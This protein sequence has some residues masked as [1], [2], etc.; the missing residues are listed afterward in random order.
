MGSTHPL[1]CAQFQ[2]N[3]PCIGIHAGPLGL[4]KRTFKGFRTL[5]ER[6]GR[7]DE[8]ANVQTH[9]SASFVCPRGC[10][11]SHS[12]FFPVRRYETCCASFPRG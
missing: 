12:P 9:C 11:S 6:K 10:M 4:D 1:A 2:N 8:L 5:L 3:L 7:L